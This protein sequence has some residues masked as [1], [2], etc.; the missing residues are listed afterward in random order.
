M[1]QRKRL[2]LPPHL[3]AVPL[4]GVR[5]PVP[6]YEW[7]IDAP[8]RN[9]IALREGSL[10]LA[11]LTPIDYARESSLYYIVPG[12]AVS[13]R[14]GD[15]TVAL[16]FREGLHRLRSLAIDPSSASE[17][18]LARVILAEQFDL[19][20]AMVPYQG[21]PGKALANA[22]AVLVVGDTALRM[23]QEHDNSLD[24]VEEWEDMTTLPYV[25]GLWCGRENAADAEDLSLLLRLCTEGRGKVDALSEAAAHDRRL[26]SLNA[27]RIL[28]YLEGLSFDGTEEIEQGLREFIR[29]AYYHGALP[30]IPDLQYYGSSPA[31]ETDEDP[32]L[33]PPA[34]H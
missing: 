13:S 8:A 10:D 33:V 18:I 29:Y 12:I 4:T 23:L 34:V 15:G 28:E 6:P 1:K 17:I 16:L 24:L 20:P 9:A 14:G 27:P 19:R 32:P 26:G 5:D 21:A 22:D 7:I 3:Y 25:H 31:A 30:D 11:F 2:G